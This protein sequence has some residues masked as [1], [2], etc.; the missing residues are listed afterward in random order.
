MQR[1]QN[2]TTM[3]NNLGNF[4]YSGEKKLFKLL[5][6]DSLYKTGMAIRQKNLRIPDSVAN[7]LADF[8][9][10]WQIQQIST[11]DKHL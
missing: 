7:S 5:F 6:L 10:E 3:Q 9:L 2:V 8:L 4:S 11:N 1:Q